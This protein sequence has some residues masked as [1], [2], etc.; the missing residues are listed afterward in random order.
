MR[1]VSSHESL[2]ISDHVTESAVKTASSANADQHPGAAQHG[3]RARGARQQ[4]RGDAQARAGEHERDL[5]VGRALQL[6]AAAGGERAGDDRG[7]DAEPEDRPAAARDGQLEAGDRQ[8]APRRDV[9]PT[10]AGGE[11]R[12][13]VAGCSGSERGHERGGEQHQHGDHRR[14]QAVA[15]DGGREPRALPGRAR[16]SSRL[17]RLLARSPPPRRRPGRPGASWAR[18]GS[19]RP[20]RPGW[21]RGWS[22]APVSPV[23]PPP[24]RRCRPCRRR[25]WSRPWPVRRRRLG[26]RRG[27][28]DRARSARHGSPSTRRRRSAARCAPCAARTRSSCPGGRRRPRN[29]AGSRAVGR[30]GQPRGRSAVPRAGPGRWSVASANSR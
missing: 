2:G 29:R 7:R 6:R 17:D 8:P 25:R 12:H 4:Q 20:A 27:L 19:R 5:G 13:G 9:E 15:T 10:C 21:C 11:G 30:R 14:G 26:R 3:G 24:S 28:G 22:R 16:T 1:F 23:E 18:R